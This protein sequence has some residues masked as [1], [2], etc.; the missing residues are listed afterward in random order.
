MTGNSFRLWLPWLS[1]KV[2]PHVEADRLCECH[3]WNHRV[4]S[5][6]SSKPRTPSDLKGPKW[7]YTAH[8]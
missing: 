6:A 7:S 4:R 5:T 3:K 1:V 8:F 2:T